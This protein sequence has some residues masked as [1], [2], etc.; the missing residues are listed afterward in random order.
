MF[1]LLGAGYLIGAGILMSEWFGGC[2]KCFKVKK[3]SESASS[4][5][6]NP[7]SHEG[8]TPREKLNSIQSVRVR[9]KLG[10]TIDLDQNF[11]Y[12]IYPVKEVPTKHQRQVQNN[13]NCIVHEVLSVHSDEENKPDSDDDFSEEINNIFEN[14]FGEEN[15]DRDNSPKEITEEDPEEMKQVNNS[16]DDQNAVNVAT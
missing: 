4:I 16:R 5:E 1:L 8:Q 11:D 15:T 13:V 6:S 14:V 2:F 10:S 12:E 3:R 9:S 7:R